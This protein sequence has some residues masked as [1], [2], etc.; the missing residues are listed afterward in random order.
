M[1]R[2]VLD[3]L[4]ADYDS[5]MFVLVGG[6]LFAATIILML[7]IG[8]MIQVGTIVERLLPAAVR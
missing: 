7:T 2:L 5:R 4:N 6:G 3:H 1:K 8:F